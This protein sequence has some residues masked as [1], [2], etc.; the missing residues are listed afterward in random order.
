MRAKSQSTCRLLLIISFFRVVLANES[1]STSALANC[2]PN[3]AISVTYFDVRLTRSGTL[4]I[5]FTGFLNVSGNVTA[6]VV[7]LVYG[8]QILNDTISLCDLGL[9]SLCPLASGALDIPQASV[10]V[11]SIV[12]VIPGIGYT[13]PDLDSTILVYIYSASARKSIAC[14]S[15]DLSNGRTVDQAAVSWVLAAMT[16]LGLIGSAIA[17][18][19]GHLHSA[20]QLSVASLDLLSFMQSQAMFGLCS[21]R[22]PPI[23][24]SWTQIFQWTI[25]IVRIG[26][27]QSFG[28]WYLRATGGTPSTVVD[29]SKSISVIVEKRGFSDPVLSSGRSLLRRTGSN[30]SKSNENSVK[31]ITRMAYRAGIESTNVFMTAY[32]SFMFVA[33]ILFV[34]LATAR[35]GHAILKRSNNKNLPRWLE[36]APMRLLNSSRGLY[37]L[38]LTDA[39]PSIASFSFWEFTQRDSAGILVLAITWCAGTTVCLGWIAV[40]T[41][42]C[43]RRGQKSGLTAAY[44]LSSGLIDAKNVRLIQLFHTA[45]RYYFF[46]IQQLYDFTGGLTIAVSQSAPVAQAITLLVINVI[47]MGLVI[48]ARPCRERSMNGRA[49]AVAIIQFVNSICILIFSGIFKGSPM[50]ASVVGVIFCLYNAVYVLVLMGYLL[51]SWVNAIRM[52]ELETQYQSVGD[53]RESF[54]NLRAS[55]PTELM[56][57]STTDSGGPKPRENQRSTPSVHNESGER[58]T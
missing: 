21:V 38:F 18:I 50:A 2:G 4:D 9:D 14:L 11:S 32:F 26:F 34:G 17:M 27:V 52:K 22:L 43:V 48:W 35:L 37:L 54:L 31:G 39:L 47:M 36:S 45:D 30:V 53:N 46:A 16:G 56:D 42:F 23:A 41:I 7:L 40:R 25:G 1:I 20:T 57:L 5:A 55:P 10:N 3:T 33:V 19:G 12:S 8:Y 24:Q 29:N 15:A 44:T 6:D 28:R 13:V 51:T 58:H 49:I